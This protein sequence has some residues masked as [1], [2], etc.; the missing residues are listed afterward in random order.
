[1]CC[2]RGSNTE[3]NLNF[4]GKNHGFQQTLPFLEEKMVSGS[5]RTQFLVSINRWVFEILATMVRFFGNL[6]PYKKHR[7]LAPTFDSKIRHHFV[8]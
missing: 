7:F 4:E 2:H 5:N 3:E 6:G 1:M 8:R